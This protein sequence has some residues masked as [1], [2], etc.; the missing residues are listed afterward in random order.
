MAK[1]VILTVDDDAEVLN[2][3]ERD[4]RRQYRQDYRVVKAASGD[5]ALETVRQ[6]H[7]RHEP[8]ALFL[9]DER[10]P[11]MSGTQFLARARDVYPSARKVLLTAYADTEA[12]IAGINTVGL[13]HYLM[14]PWDPPEERLYPVLSE[15]LADWS[16]SYVP[17]FAGIRVAGTAWSPSSHTVRDFL[18]RHQVPYQWVDVDADASLRALAEAASPGLR[19]LPVV[20]FPDGTTM[21]EPSTRA[22][23]ERI[24]LTTAAA[25]PFYDIVIIGGGP[26][27][28]A[29]AVYGASEGLRTLLVEGDVPGGQAGTSSSIENYLGFPA[30]IGGADLARRAAAQARRFGA[31]L[32]TPAG[33]TAI[34]HAP[35]YHV[36][37]L[38]TGAEITCYAL[39]I[40]SGMHVRRLDVPGIDAFTGAGVY[41]GAALSEAAACRDRDVL[42]VGGANSAGQATM[43]FARY[44]RRVTMIVRG[45]SLAASM[46]Q[47]LV[48]RIA[49]TPN[50]EVRTR[51]RVTGAAGTG[52]LE[53]VTVEADGKPPERLAAEH[54][55]I[56][57]GTAPRT[58][59]VAG[60]VELDEQGY[61]VTGPDLLRDG[62][63]PRGW[64]L[65]RDPFLLETSVPGV[66]AAG[67][68]RHGST[69]RVASAVGEG[70]AAIGMVHRYLQTV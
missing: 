64:T 18:S 25:K 2:A 10:M 24:G 35:P 44:A 53:S 40:A 1:P 58:E 33:V 14:K 56:F 50:V 13:D 7:A 27:G 34:R 20:F 49:D 65:P 54:M 42:V 62:R 16:A 17:P 52:H 36:V 3:V 45:D 28:L 19:R 8:V 61:V 68:V 37:T 55:F 51:T 11:R 21:V 31:E 60:V 12:A 66:F 47:Y 48:S 9:V 6:L 30:G 5:E 70:S 38:D 41:Y 4:L 59:A 57:I 32:L 43:L 23:G 29:A 46:S 22:L 26:S 15:L 67:D 63:R 69:K 39:L